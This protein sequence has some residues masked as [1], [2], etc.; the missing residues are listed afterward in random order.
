MD[1]GSDGSL[2][3]DTELDNEGFEKGSDKLLSAV[4]SLTKQVTTLGAE[5]KSAFTGITS[6]LQSLAAAGNNAASKTSTSAQQAE[7]ASQAAQQTAQA[8]VK[9]AE[10]SAQAQSQA[11]QK[12]AQAH[13]KTAESTRAATTA[14]KNY[15]KELSKLE[16]KIATAKAGLADYYAELKSIEEETNITLEKTTTD[17]Q[18][19]NVLEIEQIQIEN[20]NRKY[21]KKLEILR[22]L[23]AEYNRIAAARD[24]ANSS[25]TDEQAQKATG[26]SGALKALS[27]SIRENVTDEKALD[28]AAKNI[29]SVFG[30][31]GRKVKNAS[32]QLLKLPFKAVAAS[33][34][35]AVS[36]LKL[37]AKQAQKTGFSTNG[38]VKS[39]TSMKTLLFARIKRTFISAVLGDIG[40]GL[41]QLALF[42]SKFNAQMSNIKNS[43]T[44][45]SGNIAVTVGNILSAL[46]PVITS[47][48]NLLNKAV[49]AVN[50]FFAALS[51]K[52]TYTAAKKG[53]EKF[54]ESA[55]E[56]AEA[57]KK[58]NNELYS[59][60]ELNRQSRVDD[61]SSGSKDD[62]ETSPIQYEELPI[63][64]PQGV[65]DWIDDLKNAWKNGDWYGVGEVIGE[66]LNASLK[67]AD[68]WINNTLRPKGVEWAK[69]AA[70]ILNGLFDKVDWPL[71]GKTV[72]DGCNAI[73]D[74][75][76]N[77]FTT[78]KA[79]NLGSGIGSAIKSWFDNIDW[80]LIG[81]TFANGWNT[82]LHII[83]G[84]VTTPG[85]WASIG[86]SVGQFVKSWFTTIDLNSIATSLIATF[87]GVTELINTFLDQNPFEGVAEKIYT[88]IN[89]VLHE[90]NWA[91]LGAAISRLFITVLKNLV[92][93][94]RE[95][96]WSQVGYAVGQALSNVNWGEVFSQVAQFIGA[97]LKAMFEFLGGMIKGDGGGIL[98]LAFTWL[99]GSLAVKLAGAIFKAPLQQAL[100]SVIA[101][102]LTGIIGGS[103]IGG[104]GTKI[105]TAGK[106]VLTTIIGKIGGI[107]TKI[108][109]PISGALGKIVSSIT[110]GSGIAGWG[111]KI[112]TAGK[113]VVTGLIGKIG[114]IAAKVLPAIGATLTKIVTGIVSAIGG[115]PVVII[116]AAAAVI[117]ALVIWIKNGGGEVIQGFIDGA[118]EKWE[119]VKQALRDFADLWITGFKSLF[120]IHSPS[121]V[122]AEQGGYVMDGLLQGISDKWPKISEFLSNGVSELLSTL[123]DGWKQI[124]SNAKEN[125]ENLKS[126]V[127]TAFENTRT[128]IQDTASQIGSNLRSKWGEVKSDAQTAWTN[129]RTTLS[130]TMGNV[131]NSVLNTATNMRTN[132]NSTFGGIVSNAQTTWGNLQTATLNKFSALQQ[133]VM[134][135][136]TNLRT[137]L[138]N[139]QWNNV[140]HNLVAGLN[141]GV[142]GAWGGFMSN[143][144]NM[145][146]N[147]IRRIRNLFGIHS[148][149]TV[150]AEIGE[151][152]DMG[153]EKGMN[154]GERSLLSTAKNIATAVTDGMTP[155]TPNVQMNVDSVVGSM[156]AIIS[157]LGSLAVTFQTIANALTSIGGFT[158]PNIAAGTVVPYQTRVAAHNAPA[159]SEGGVEAYLLG[160]LSELQ[161]L[162]RSVRNG[163]GRQAQPLIVSVGGRE[164]FQIVVDENNRAVRTTGKSP[165]TK[166]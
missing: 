114:G 101:D 157:S 97:A 99:A 110:G 146:N 14:T 126:N 92:T 151:Y 86:Q 73:A 64:L 9:A 129:L 79:K 140:G 123:S 31:M 158:M 116:A 10:Q 23:E 88:A 60:D 38:L 39:L 78:F 24:A 148:P 74:I 118:K 13:E 152:L 121:T 122:M 51:G 130:N 142:A 61:S 156:Q 139:V 18:A 76:N 113:G 115:W 125:W 6:I 164:I 7:R 30:D 137:N 32:K 161:A 131:R 153:L 55:E 21:A 17:E 135:A 57:Q 69:R 50:Q 77:F 132:L 22:Q 59:F 44:Q 107:A 37:F 89:R 120:G 87:N 41:Q 62:T 163:D 127:T 100:T 48:I 128:K 84:I 102:L 33:A 75:L 35:L 47:I 71:L 165:L 53:N 136:W 34:K 66:G 162:S 58:F 144:S 26:L 54:A 52:T 19:A 20:T 72:A 149:S 29:V 166:G 103:G 11:A 147:L 4:D 91:E 2:V 45:L 111:A 94:V 112:L 106:G 160:I 96:D 16:K 133:N 124:T 85:L 80:P 36:G 25:G 83:E 67:V 5:M 42:D 40:E 90:V 109:S 70:E 28:A 15:D 27:Q 134:K 1:N 138:N 117:T 119:A 143:V 65:M 155:D 56:A 108:W 63:N 95:I 145:V 150:F 8:Q 46:E 43:L 93:V 104:W 98:I 105:L 82:I 141:N 12:T 3:F 154:D 49:T 81:Q 159:G 68:D